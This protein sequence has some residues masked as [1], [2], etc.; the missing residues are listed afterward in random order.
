M[1]PGAL[2]KKGG[3][4]EGLL[5]AI[6]QPTNLGLAAK[7][8]TDFLGPRYTPF[9][10]NLSATCASCVGVGGKGAGKQTSTGCAHEAGS[11]GHRVSV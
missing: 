3:K 6:A 4:F 1:K 11:P 9:A 8:K 2:A 10:L 5:R 7:N